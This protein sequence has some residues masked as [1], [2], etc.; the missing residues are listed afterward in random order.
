MNPNRPQKRTANTCGACRARKVRCDGRR[1]ICTNCERLGL[2]CSYDDAFAVDVANSL[3]IPRRRVRQAC[4]NC[5][6]KKARCSG[7]MPSCD[8]CRTQ[9]L[10]CV[11]R[12]GKRAL[13]PL[14]SPNGAL[15]PETTAVVED[16]TSSPSVVALD[17]H[18]EP[19]EVLARR[20]FDAFFRHIHHIPMFAFLHQASLME[21]YDKGALDRA[22]V[23]AL[24]GITVLLTDLGQGMDE[25]GEQCIEEAI[26]MCLR[27]L[28]KPS[29]PRL[30]ALAIAVKHRILSKRHSS[31]FMLHGIAGRF[32]TALRLNHEQPSICFLAQESR[33]RL[34]WSLYMIDSS[35]SA[36]QQES[37]LWPDAERQIHVQLP[38]NERNFEFDLPEPTEPLRPPP[39]GP[40]GTV[41]PMPD[42]LGFMAA[43][44]RIQWMRTRILQYTS[45]AISVSSPNDLAML[46]MQCAELETELEAF[47]TRLPPSFRWSEANL[48]LR[49]YSRRL[50][51]FV[52]THVWWR[53]CHL[54]LYR[55]CL[56][57]LREALSPEALQHLDPG[58]VDRC[59]QKCY[60]HA[61]AM[62]DMFAQMMTLGNSAV[63]TDLDLPGCAFQCSKVLYH[64][65]Q[66]DSAS[67][68][69]TSERVR[70]L[71]NVCLKA[72]KQS[73]SGLASA[74]IQA[75]IER[76][77]TNGLSLPESPPRPLVYTGLPQP[78]T[79][80]HA[81]QQQPS[82]QVPMMPPPLPQP[83]PTTGAS[84]PSFSMGIPDTVIPAPVA[85][86]H[87]SAVTTG[88]NAFEE[89]IMEGLNFGFGGPELYALDWSTFSNG[90]ANPTH[91]PGN[92]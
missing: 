66:T 75:D 16:G 29:I 88:S 22:L 12:P 55:L 69:F 17:D 24:I 49:A 38:C 36:G 74:S 78:D 72:A 4:Q 76:L 19:D 89:V 23:L 73:T 77:I 32:A 42:A 2:P 39:P 18:L 62:P 50:G 5:H 58:F 80:A 43:H 34:M 57:G 81:E 79:V 53:Q 14:L 33:R 84:M 10:E 85:P 86:S 48:R 60:D 45:R 26:S 92:I 31:A 3:A 70:E 37:A 56:T 21:R 44:I 51:I 90:W 59:R 83:Q 82:F 15:S 91:F 9:N 1:G 64:G 35:I 8:R 65:L 46:P 47:E 63:V 87:A 68:G 67:L 71:V 7:T 40:D 61:R 52:M 54:D 41:P 30:Q 6:S 13:P 20:A 25:Y 27:E 28:E 11:Y